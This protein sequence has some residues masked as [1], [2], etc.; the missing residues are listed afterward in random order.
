MTPCVFKR[1]S[2]ARHPDNTT[3][4]YTMCTVVELPSSLRGYDTLPPVTRLSHGFCSVGRGKSNLEDGLFCAFC[5]TRKKKTRINFKRTETTKEPTI[6]KIYSH[7]DGLSSGPSPHSSSCSFLSSHY[8]TI[9]SA[10]KI[11][12]SAQNVRRHQDF[13]SPPHQKQSVLG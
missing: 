9:L 4:A 8:V 12:G 3:H 7:Q 6:L 13:R 10:D 1:P 5:V 2:S 11:L